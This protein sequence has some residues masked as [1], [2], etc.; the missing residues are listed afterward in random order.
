MGK[1]AHV[2]A[3]FADGEDEGRLQYEP[4]KLIFRGR[5]RRAFEGPTLA[6]VRAEA[7]AL[8]LADGSRF[9]LG[10]RQAANWASAILNPKG[11]LE[12]LG[13]KAG[14]TLGISNLDDPAFIAE[15]ESAGCAPAS[16]APFDIL[17]H[18]ADS[19]AELAMIAD[20]APGL[21]AGG[22]LW[23]VSLKGKAAR[24]TDVEVM[25][26]ARPRGLVGVKVCAFSQEK[27]ALKFVRRRS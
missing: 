25:A 16:A 5:E 20:L 22:A 23:V 13:V 6:G 24:V 3:R 11:R 21:A 27:T 12:K 17:F 1:E 10:E 7:G 14:L 9:E 26:A 8:V 15:L 4:P 18:G 19:A 2:R